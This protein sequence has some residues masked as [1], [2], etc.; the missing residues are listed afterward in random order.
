MRNRSRLFRLVVGAVIALGSAAMATPAVQASAPQD[1]AKA[2]A[3]LAKRRF[4]EGQYDVAARLFVRAYEMS[5]RPV[6]LFNAG[7]AREMQGDGREAVRIYKQYIEVETDVAGREE[8]RARIQAIE[9]GHGQT[10][11]PRVPPDEGKASE[12]KGKKDADGKGKG[13]EPMKEAGNGPWQFD[14]TVPFQKTGEHT[15]GYKAGP[16]VIEAV[17]VRNMPSAGDVADAAKDRNDNSHPK[18]SV[19]LSNS[20]SDEIEAK[21]KVSLETASGE[22]L[23]ACDGKTSLDGQAHNDHLNLCWIASIKTIDWPQVA[24]VHVVATVVRK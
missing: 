24:K 4:R 22:V 18:F 7:R 9:E 23:M 16:L 17:T 2:V 21:V 8:A 6:L 19:G 12:G 3:E 13:A 1:D 11:K 5:K 14:K 20:G 15:M 10:E